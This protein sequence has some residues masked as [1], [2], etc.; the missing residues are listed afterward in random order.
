ME[1]KRIG[2]L[3]SIEKQS[4]KPRE[5]ESYTLFSLPAFDNRKKPE[6]V[7]GEEIKSSKLNLTDNTILFNKL[8]VQFKRVWNIKK[9]FTA[10]NICS[11]EFL[12]LKVCEKEVVQDYLY[13]IL[14]GRELTQAMYGARR[15]TSG[16]Q[17]R[18]A[19][20]T[21]LN[22]EVPVF[23]ID[24]QVKIASILGDLDERIE[25]N[26]EVNDNLHSQ[27][28]AIYENATQNGEI[29]TVDEIVDFYDSMRKPLSS[30][31]RTGMERIYP[32]YGAANIVDYVDDYI[33][34]GIYILLSEDGANVVDTFGY[35]LIQFAYGKFWVNNHAHVLKG[36]SG[37]TDALAYVVLKYTNMKSIVTGAAQPKINQAN[38]R[39]LKVIIPPAS[40][41][42]E[43]NEIMTEMF[44]QILINDQEN[45]RLEEMKDTLLPKLLAGEID[46]NLL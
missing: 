26:N 45:V 37:L 22:Y 30:K 42:T 21:L 3:C 19:P 40:I 20:E 1:H 17:Q 46:L 29:C 31:E 15:G 11:T 38:L 18:I 2:D 4:V 35:P 5:G 28:K 16:S 13:Y 27:L 44:E 14:T 12:P 36:K 8:N 34:D 10:N 25:L 23:S 9:L 24:E 41:R 43:I 6:I 33:F 39:A 7:D 32:Y